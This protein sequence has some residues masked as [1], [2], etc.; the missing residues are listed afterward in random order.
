MHALTTAMH[1]GVWTTL[2]STLTTYSIT[3]AKRDHACNIL[4][5]AENKF[6]QAT[7]VLQ[8]FVWVQGESLLRLRSLLSSRLGTKHTQIRKYREQN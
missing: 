5:P 2:N 6:L 7:T 4:R 3:I 1:L 8:D